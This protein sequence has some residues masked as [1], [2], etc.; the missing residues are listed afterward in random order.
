MEP[1]PQGTLAR[2]RVLYVSNLEPDYYGEYRL[3]TLRRLG[4]DH[5]AALGLRA[6]GALELILWRT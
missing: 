6:Y 5:V 1:Q 3:R 4:L 2:L